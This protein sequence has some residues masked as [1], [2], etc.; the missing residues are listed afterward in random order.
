[1]W[2][3]DLHWP[4]FLGRLGFIVTVL[5]VAHAGRP[6]HAGRLR[7]TW[8]W[9]AGL[10]VVLGLG[11]AI[12][13][14]SLHST[15]AAWLWLGAWLAHL[16]QLSA[17]LSEID[18]RPRRWA[19]NVLLALAAGL[20]P[21]VVGQLQGRFSDEEFFVAVQ[22]AMVSLFWLLLRLPFQGPVRQYSRDA[23][24]TGVLTLNWRGIAVCWILVGSATGFITL[25]GYQRSFYAQSAPQYD[26]IA[27]TTP[28][29]CGETAPN[30]HVVSGAAVF[31]R[32]VEAVAAHPQKGPPEYGML[33]LST[34]QESWARVSGRVC[35][36]RRP[37]ND[38][39][40]PPRA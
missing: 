20:L 28:F 5:L 34:G 33:A 25:R 40:R 13:S 32:L 31:N 4:G 15:I 12:I 14:L 9:P 21:V 10:T 19:M 18:S 26:Q 16:L 17:I 39:A 37:H 36:K 2:G 23:R 8:S 29:L 3:M 24:Q 22:A 6:R 38:S 30:D 27:P 7:W 11:A 35:C 1:M